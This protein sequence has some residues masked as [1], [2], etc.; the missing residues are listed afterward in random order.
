M[1]PASI[2][3]PPWPVRRK[4]PGTLQKMPPGRRGLEQIAK[5]GTAVAL[6]LI[7][8]PELRAKVK[9]EFAQWQEYGLETGMV[10][11]DALRKR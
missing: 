6:R 8:E 5:I 4:S 11:K 7:L 9:E 1:S 2:S 3:I 10:T